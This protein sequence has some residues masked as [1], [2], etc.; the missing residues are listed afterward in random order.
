MR[1]VSALFV[2]LAMCSPGASAQTPPLLK[3][4]VPFPAGGAAD[5][6]A[7]LWGEDVKNGGGPTVV[8]ENRPGG[9]AII[10]TDLVSRAAPDG[11]T[12]G[13]VA[14]SF[15]IT[16]AI[17]KLP[18]DPFKN[19]EHLCRLIDSPQ[20][21]AVNAA[22]PYKTYDELI[23][24]A[25]ARP[26]TLMLGANG[27]ATTQHVVAE[28]LKKA[29][30]ANMTFVPF[31]GA[32]PSVTS[33]MGGQTHVVVAN[34]AEVKAFIDSGGLRAVLVTSPQRIAPLPDVPTARE[35][36]LGFDITNWFGMVGTGASPKPA[37]DALQG[38]AKKALANASIIDKL[39]QAQLSPA[40][41]CG[42]DF[43]AFL[44]EQYETYAAIARE[45]GIKDES[46]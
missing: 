38:Y 11:G 15:L 46:P 4:V 45:A 22:S 37:V 41:L 34:Y 21:V 14:P 39:A 2:A 5:I 43:T 17:R 28:M 30:K 23:A 32:A 24:A 8:V 3:V 29:S 6:V 36:G 13:I 10:G 44:R 33:L 7:R 12:V 27:P 26:G 19:F 18:Y 40:V 35:K 1:M 9:S 25:H 20:I 16:A 31:N 42:A